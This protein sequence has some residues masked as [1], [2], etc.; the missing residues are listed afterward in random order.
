M[1]HLHLLWAPT[2]PGFPPGE[3]SDMNRWVDYLVMEEEINLM[4]GPSGLCFNNVGG[5]DQQYVSKDSGIY[6]SRI[7]EDGAADQD[8]RL[9]EGD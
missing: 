9:Q 6:D 1:Y 4:R 7:K 3:Q 8:G 5:T 2:D